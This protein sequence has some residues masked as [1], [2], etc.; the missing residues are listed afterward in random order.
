[1]FTNIMAISQRVLLLARSAFVGWIAMLVVWAL[2]V[3]LLPHRVESEIGPVG[4]FFVFSLVFSA[5]YLVNFLSITTPVYFLLLFADK[6]GPARRWFQLFGVGLYLLSVA[7]WCRAYDTRPEWH[8]YALAATAGAASLYALSSSR[9][10]N[11][12]KRKTAVDTG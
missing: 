12:T 11:S 10:A 1:M 9:P 5:M 4:A 8:L 6:G 2:Y 7:S 3:F